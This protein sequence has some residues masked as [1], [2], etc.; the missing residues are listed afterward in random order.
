MKKLNFKLKTKAQ[1]EQYLELLKTDSKVKESSIAEQKDGS[2][3][4]EY[5]VA[6]DIAAEPEKP[7]TIN[8]VYEIVNDYND[9][10]VR[11]LGRR[12]DFLQAQVFESFDALSSHVRNGHLPPIKGAEKLQKALEI[13]KIDG[14]YEIE[15]PVIYSTAT[16]IDDKS[17]DIVFELTSKK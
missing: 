14:D 6:N 16:S 7:L 15:K 12:I 9:W 10:Y 3:A 1:A 5:S 11:D 8:M 2:F 13:L 17:K 4:V